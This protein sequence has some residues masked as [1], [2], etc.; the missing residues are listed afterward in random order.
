MNFAK[1]FLLRNNF[2]YIAWFIWSIFLFN[3]LIYFYQP[4][5]ASEENIQ[6]SDHAS[7]LFISLTMVALLEAAATIVFRYFA[8]IRPSKKG[9]YSPPSGPI[10]FLLVGF[11][12]W[13]CSNS[14]IIYGLVLYYMTGS[15]RF[16]LV[17]GPIG[18]VLLIFHSPRLGPFKKKMT[19]GTDKV[20]T[21]FPQAT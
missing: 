5:I 12:N 8:L 6:K 13:V 9:T 4:F 20:D 11:V 14:I 2:K 18:L 10:R 19:S 15:P 1:I 3:A 16:L 7:I 21:S 17:F